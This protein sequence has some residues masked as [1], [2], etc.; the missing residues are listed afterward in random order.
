MERELYNVQVGNVTRTTWEDVRQGP[1][2]DAAAFGRDSELC[3]NEDE[4]V[5]GQNPLNCHMRNFMTPNYTQIAFPNMIQSQE[6]P[7][8]LTWLFG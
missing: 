5:W 6:S 2:I 3:C 7:S 8:S 4:L 1:E